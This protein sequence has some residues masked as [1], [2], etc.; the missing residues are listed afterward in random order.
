MPIENLYM[1][2][3]IEKSIG[4]LVY[5]FLSGFWSVDLIGLIG[6]ARGPGIVCVAPVPG[7]NPL[8][9]SARRSISLVIQQSDRMK[10][11]SRFH[12]SVLKFSHAF[13]TA[14]S[15]SI[16]MS[17]VNTASGYS[18]LALASLASSV[19]TSCSSLS[20]IP[21]QSRP[22]LF[23]VCLCIRTCMTAWIRLFEKHRWLNSNGR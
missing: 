19:G 5:F 23:S 16:P 2:L 14:S 8:I 3:Y 9:I 7:S 6:L 12:W 13:F 10:R 1:N 17:S 22:F 15:G 4:W 20:S 11:D 21:R 18:P